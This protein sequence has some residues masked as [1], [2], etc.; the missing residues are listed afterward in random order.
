MAVEDTTQTFTNL[1]GSILLTVVVGS[2]T[3]TWAVKH[4]ADWVDV[5]TYSAD[6]AE[7]ID[8]GNGR[9]HR[10]TVTGDATYAF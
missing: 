8:T 7:I 9:E 6:A 3:V 10:F 5:V 2:G 1:N 4:G